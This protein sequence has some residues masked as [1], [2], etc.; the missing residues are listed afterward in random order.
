M[1]RAPAS[2]LI[3]VSFFFFF[4][5]FIIIIIIIIIIIFKMELLRSIMLYLNPMLNEGSNVR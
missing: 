2:T 4:F 1:T 5:F 3:G